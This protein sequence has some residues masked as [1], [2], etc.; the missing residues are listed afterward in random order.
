MIRSRNKSLSS[1]GQ[2]NFKMN[3]YL[4]PLLI[5]GVFLFAGTD[6]VLSQPPLKVGALVPFTGRYGD[7]G[8][9]CARGILDA[10]RG[11]NQRG[12]IYGRRLE[13]VLV[14]DASQT[15]ETI[16][17]YRKLN[18]ADNVLLL[19]V[20]LMD[21]A[22]SLTSHIQFNRLPTLVSALPSHLLTP[23]KHPYFFSL[24]PTPLIKPRL[25]SRISRKNRAPGRENPRSFSSG[26]PITPTNT[27]WMKESFTQKTWGWMWHWISSSRILPGSRS[28][29]LT[30]RD[31]RRRSRFSLP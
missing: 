6:R 14:D 22:I 16:A 4:I 24:V 9:E 5:M 28:T 1:L 8:R 21:T 15:A 27:F 2:W 31:H 19:Y 17:A 18:E 20:Y 3:R 7:S 23:S 25:E 29:R 12:G 10:A 11:L 30:P 26:L 13:I